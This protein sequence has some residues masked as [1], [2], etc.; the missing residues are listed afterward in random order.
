MGTIP[1]PIIDVALSLAVAAGEQAARN[2]VDRIFRTDNGGGSDGD[3]PERK[4][5]KKR[6]KQ[7]RKWK[8]ELRRTK[9]DIRTLKKALKK[10]QAAS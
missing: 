4:R 8:R 2:A 9:A 3:Y 7:R 1:K 10:A 5:K 6:G